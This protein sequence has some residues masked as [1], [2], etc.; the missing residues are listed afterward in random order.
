MKVNILMLTIAVF[1]CSICVAKTK[2][3]NIGI[4][5]A[6]FNDQLVRPGLSLGLEKSIWQKIKTKKDGKIKLRNIV[7]KSNVGFFTQYRHSTSLFFNTT[8]GFRFT[9]KTG[10]TIDPLHIGF[11]FMQ[12]FLNGKTFVVDNNGNVSEKK[13]ASNSNLMLPYISL[14][15][16]GYDF[17]KKM[18]KPFA[19]SISTDFYFQKLITQ[20]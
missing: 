2:K 10:F 15:G 4:K 5:V 18:D 7:L 11:G 16:F 9:N 8:I 20:I 13:L 3:S 12:T 14:I 6:Y 1:A 19:I 17:R